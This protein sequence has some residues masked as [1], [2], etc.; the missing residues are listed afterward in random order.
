MVVEL[1]VASQIEPI[2][3]AQLVSYMKTLSK[4]VGL[5]FRFGGPKPEFARWVLTALSWSDTLHPH[6]VALRETDTLLYQELTYEI[7]GGALDVLSI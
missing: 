3:L 6:C 4:Q 1:K 5:L 2:H 7:I